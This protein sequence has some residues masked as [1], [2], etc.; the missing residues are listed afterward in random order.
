MPLLI[1]FSL[2][3]MTP[4]A[5]VREH[6]ATKVRSESAR[7]ASRDG[8]FDLAQGEL[9][10]SL[11]GR[12][13]VDC[14]HYFLDRSKISGAEISDIQFLGVHFTFANV[15][16]LLNGGRIEWHTLRQ[17]LNRITASQ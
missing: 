9:R 7:F 16:H 12:R 8:P 3:R 4:D 14:C 17:L 1:T 2:N 11:H 10:P 15:E 13:F 6:L 5:F